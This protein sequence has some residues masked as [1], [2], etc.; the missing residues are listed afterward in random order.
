MFI[1]PITI[2]INIITITIII[3]TNQS[4]DMRAR[5]HAEAAPE[6]KVLDTYMCGVYI[7]I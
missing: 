3:V 6:D 7:Y 2:I 1:I 5:H 4:Y